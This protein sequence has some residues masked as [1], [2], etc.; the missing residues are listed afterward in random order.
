MPGGFGGRF[1]DRLELVIGHL[2]T[3]A[4]PFLAL[5]PQEELEDLLSEG[6][7]FA[8]F[9][10]G[11]KV[12]ILGAGPIGLATARVLSERGTRVTVTDNGNGTATLAG[13]PAPGTASGAAAARTCCRCASTRCS[14]R[15]RCRPSSRRPPD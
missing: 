5:V 8:G 9:A 11:D 10:A 2:L 4:L 6:A 7:G 1:D 12:L 3:V 13:T 15:T 14:S